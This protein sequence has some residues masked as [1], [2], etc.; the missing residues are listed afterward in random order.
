[1][2]R[3]FF[4]EDFRRV[5]YNEIGEICEP[6]DLKENY[7]DSVLELLN[8]SAIKQREFKVAVNLM[9]G[10]TSNVYPDI[11]NDLNIDNIILNAYLDD[12]KLSKLPT[13]IKKSE[14]E[15][16]A[17]VK[18]LG[19]DMGFLIYPNGQRLELVCEEGRVL[20]NHI[21]LLIILSLLNLNRDEK[22][23]VFLPAW[24][25]D[26]TDSYFENLIITRDKFTNFKARDRNSVV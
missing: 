10:S 24:A 11:V 14:N 12:K 2:E 1:M 19:L 17:I 26:F 20:E 16:S 21:T 3:L 25:P 9:F 4:R 5:N 15:V 22:S 8:K 6:N 7:K 13:L 23:K 18:S